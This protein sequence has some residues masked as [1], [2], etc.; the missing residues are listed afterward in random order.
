MD[1]NPA[2]ILHWI[3]VETRRAGRKEVANFYR[4]FVPRY[5]SD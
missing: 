5:S 1:V 4:K 3:L 2:I